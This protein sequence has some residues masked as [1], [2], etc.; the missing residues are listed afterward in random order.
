MHV[1]IA[2]YGPGHTIMDQAEA[3]VYASHFH[4]GTKLY[5]PGQGKPPR[6]LPGI[7]ALTVI[8]VEIKDGKITAECEEPQEGTNDATK[9]P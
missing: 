3:L 7:Y 6:D 2:N 9:H 8:S 1:E 4:P 5:V